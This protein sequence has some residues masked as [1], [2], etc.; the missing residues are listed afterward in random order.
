[1]R[2]T[3]AA[4][5]TDRRQSGF[6]LVE[7]VAAAALLALGIAGLAAAASLS[8]RLNDASA[9]LDRARIAIQDQL[10]DL[11]A[12][13]REELLARA[14]ETRSFATR[15]GEPGTLRI[16][17]LSEQDAARFCGTPLDLDADGTYDEEEATHSETQILAILVAATWND[18]DGWRTIEQVALLPKWDSPPSQ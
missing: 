11:E 15:R 17:L 3:G 5:P 12:M 14:G 13:P 18:A 6:S 16:T 1:M 7:V 2:D 8:I 9:D 4:Q 10:E